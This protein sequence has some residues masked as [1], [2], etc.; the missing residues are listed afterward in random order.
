MLSIHILKSMTNLLKMKHILRN[1]WSSSNCE[2]IINKNEKLW[3]KVNV[4]D[5]KILKLLRVPTG[6]TI[7]IIFLYLA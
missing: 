5:Y 2:D 4:S 6:S 3:I 7:Q 1:A